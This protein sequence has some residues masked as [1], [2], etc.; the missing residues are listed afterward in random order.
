MIILIQQHLARNYPDFTQANIDC[1]L[2]WSESKGMPLCLDK[3]IVLHW[4]E[5]NPY[6]RNQC[7]NGFLPAAI[8]FRDLGVIRS[9]ENTYTEH[10]S[11]VAQR[12]RQL[13]DQCFRAFLS[14]NPR[15]LL[16]VSCT[17]VLLILNYGSPV[18]L[19]RLSQ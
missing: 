13:I 1:V 7:S 9:S 11:K 15:F 2:V 10:F 17:Y 4:D 19:P 8:S 14:R 16:R 18:W 12:G 3:C 5:S 6:H